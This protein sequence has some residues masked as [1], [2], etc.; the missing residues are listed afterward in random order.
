MNPFIIYLTAVNF[1]AFCLAG[2]DKQRAVTRKYRV[3]ENTLMLSAVIGGGVGLMLGFLLF[4]HK[5]RK[6][7][8]MLGVP[9]I[10]VIQIIIIYVFIHNFM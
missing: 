2:A 8:F 10:M 4:R 3:P 5:T 1:F 7:K 6:T 9:A